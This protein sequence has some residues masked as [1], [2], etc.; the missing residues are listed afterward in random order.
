[1]SLAQSP[2]NSDYQGWNFDNVQPGITLKHRIGANGVASGQEQVI[3]GNLYQ[4]TGNNNMNLDE[5]KRHK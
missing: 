1:M 4:S 5:Y 2:K 3:M